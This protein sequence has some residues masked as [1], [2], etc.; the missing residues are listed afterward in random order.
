MKRL[1]KPWRS[2][3]H[4]VLEVHDTDRVVGISTQKERMSDEAALAEISPR[5][6]VLVRTREL[7]L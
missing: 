1:D 4:L 3:V 6:P 5:E 2:S 7:L